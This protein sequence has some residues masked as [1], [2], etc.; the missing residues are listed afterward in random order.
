MKIYSFGWILTMIVSS[1]VTTCAEMVKEK[2]VD[3]PEEPTVKSDV[4]QEALEWADSVYS[5]LT[6]EQRL[7]QMLMPAI[8]SDADS[9]TLR[10]VEEYA[11]EIRVGGLLLLKGDVGS[12]MTIAAT[13]DSIR[14]VTPFSPGFF[15]AMDAETGLGMRLSD[16][17]E[18]PWNRNISREA[19]ESEFFE[20][21]AE[22]G[23]EASLTGINM[24]LGPVVDVD[25]AENEGHGIMKNR[26]LG[27]DQL[28]V[29]RLSLAYARGL[30][31]R[32][33]MGVPKHFPGH[34]PT[35]S[36]S[37]RTLPVIQASKD[38]IYTVDLLPFRNAVNNGLSCIMVGHI[39]APALDS[40]CRPASFSPVIIQDILRKDMGFNGIVLVDAVGMQG[41][42]GFSAADAIMAGADIIIAPTD[43]RLELQKLLEAVEQGRISLS[44]IEQ[45]VKRIL[46]HKYLHLISPRPE[47]AS[48]PLSPDTLKERLF[49]EAPSIISKLKTQPN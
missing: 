9:F 42:Q 39:W 40:V 14:K 21:G 12:A 30:E 27:S 46:F 1:A 36:D 13:L 32:G 38:E 31:S 8:Y 35:T 29:S 25:R 5:Y 44:T 37:H 19:D 34:G 16:A 47:G 49:E 23:R 11:S 33:V 22:V 48:A 2:P 18:F 15:L 45:S 17:P 10:R 7:A 4:T 26:S 43:T 3:L 28:R 41:A 24:I 6:L 20:Y